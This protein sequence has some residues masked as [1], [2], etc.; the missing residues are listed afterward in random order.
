MD[1]AMAAYPSDV[2]KQVNKERALHDSY[3]AALLKKHGISSE[4]MT[5]IITE[6]IQNQW[7]Y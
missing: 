1:E 4:Q 2:K 7:T 3:T 6:G 5:K